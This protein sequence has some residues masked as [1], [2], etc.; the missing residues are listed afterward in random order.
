M[1]GPAKQRLAGVGN[2]ELLHLTGKGAAEAAQSGCRAGRIIVTDQP[3]E[4][5]SRDCTLL[6][7]RAL[8]K[9][10]AIAMAWQGQ[11]LRQR[12]A[13]DLTGDRPWSY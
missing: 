4:I 8:R 10:G 2:V 6:D 13:R 9:S 1:E 5:R 7:V 11:Q 12:S 3:V